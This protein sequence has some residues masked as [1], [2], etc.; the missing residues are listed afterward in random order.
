MKCLL[1]L[2]F[3]YT[4]SLAASIFDIVDVEYD[5]VVSI[6]A[7][8]PE[9]TKPVKPTTTSRTV[10]TTTTIEHFTKRTV[11]T[12]TRF[13]TTT[14][15]AKQAFTSTSPTKSLNYAARMGANVALVPFLAILCLMSKI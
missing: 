4:M 6:D 15:L 14:R 13:V 5:D 10:T 7:N 8:V 12:P 11:T 3:L 2:S 1:V 9:K